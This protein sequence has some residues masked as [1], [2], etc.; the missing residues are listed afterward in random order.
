MNISG[1]RVIH[2]VIVLCLSLQSIW[3][4]SLISK[5]KAGSVW[6]VKV[7][8]ANMD[9]FLFAINKRINTNINWGY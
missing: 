9:I 1:S 4:L 6:K 3:T 5:L 8:S 7:V 2:I